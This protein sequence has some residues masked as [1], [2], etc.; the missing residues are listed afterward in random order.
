M[1]VITTLRN[2]YLQP[3][4]DAELHA[5]RSD[6]WQQYRPAPPIH[7]T[8][9]GTS[10][11]FRPGLTLTPFANPV[12][13]NAHCRFCSEELQRRD[14]H[15]LT[16]KRL[17]LDYDRYF[18]GLTTALHAL[19]GLPMGLSLSGL[20]ATAEPT[21]LHSL[22]QT[23]AETAGVTPFDEKVLYTNGSGL[24][25]HAWMADALADSRFDR[26]ELSRCHYDDAVNQS[27]MY[28]NRNEPV[29]QNAPYEAL[30]RRL[31][32][33]WP[34]QVKNS[35]ILTQPG[36][37]DLVEME[38]Y[39]DWVMDLGVTSVVFR[40]LS[41][42]DATYLPNATA[43]WVEA[44]RI[45]IEPILQALSPSMSGTRAGWRYAGSTVGYYYYNEHFRYRDAVEVVVETSSYPALR[46][47]NATGIVQKLVYHS[48]GHLCGDWDPDTFVIGRF[49]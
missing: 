21:W 31:H 15:Q 9:Q 27:I 13:C 37:H 6:Q 48:N 8:I 22:L 42:L 23:L 38:R 20:E 49:A 11:A 1:E 30:V 36:V 3:Q 10:F 45:A 26:I 33:Q 2:L 24:H 35:C 12:P 43:R 7:K 17:I 47:A 16:A 18:A 25:R 46:T 28:F 4:D 19:G 41:R 39:L 5:L 14:G 34:V 40:E 32:D 29:W 44:N